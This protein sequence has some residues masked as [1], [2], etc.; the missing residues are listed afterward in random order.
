MFLPQE[1]LE[2]AS[3]I[4]GVHLIGVNDLASLITI[5]SGDLPLPIH[6][7]IDPKI[8][9]EKYKTTSNNTSFEH[10]IGQ[11]HAKRALV[12]AAV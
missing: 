10:I 7:P 6:T 1:N 4:P 9:I 8:Y 12:I 2:E 5:L 11:E 3:L